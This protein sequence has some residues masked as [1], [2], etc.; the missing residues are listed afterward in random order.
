MRQKKQTLKRRADG[1]YVC[2]IGDRYFFGNTS[3]EALKARDDYKAS[4]TSGMKDDGITVFAYALRWVQTYKA[5]LTTGPYNTCVRI[6]NRFCDEYGQRHLRYIDTIDIQS[7]YNEYNGKSESSIHDMRDTIRGLF[8][9]AIADRI[10]TYDP[11]M[12]AK[13]PSGTS[14]SHRAITL[15][16]RD[17]I[18]R[19]KHSLRPT[20]MVM[21]YAGLRRGE[22]LALNIDR[23]VDFDNGIIHVRESVRFE[24]ENQPVIVS[25]KTAA[26]TRVVP[27]LSILRPVLEGITGLLAPSASGGYMSESA[28]ASAWSSYISALETELNGIQRRWYGRTKEQMAMKAAGTLPEWKDV[29]IRPHDLRHSFATMLRDSGADLKMSMLIMGHSDQSMLLRIYDHPDEYRY[30]MTA[31]NIEKLLLCGQ[32]GGQSIIR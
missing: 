30:K 26:G 31:E 21:L 11:T 29:T 10:I 14:G 28:W 17:L 6:L 20:I 16:E 8:K 23:D 7:F 5:H 4:H 9:G 19:T 12:K 1:R 15:D 27:L 3:D 24:K 32:N 13:L 2:R 22:A 18:L 25:P